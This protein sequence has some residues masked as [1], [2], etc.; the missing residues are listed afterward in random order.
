MTICSALRRLTAITMLIAAPA[1]A[2]L[3]ASNPPPQEAPVLAQGAHDFDFLYGAWTVHNRRL[4]ARLAHSH[5]WV[6]FEARDAFHPLAGGMGSENY[7]RTDYGP[8]CNA[9]GLHLYKPRS[10]QWTLYWADN[11]SF[12]GTVQV[13]ATGAFAQSVGTLLRSGHFQRRT[14]RSA[15]HL[16]DPDFAASALG[17]GVLERRR[18][19]LGNRLDHGFHAA[20]IGTVRKAYEEN[21]CA[22]HD[23]VYWQRSP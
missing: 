19:V 3:P 14:H 13:L 2:E 17:T 18:Q 6:R 15:H 4:L 20:V 1:E 16:A 12:D 22:T 23:I 10:G 5:E 21:W 11:R 7:Y 9:I 8:G